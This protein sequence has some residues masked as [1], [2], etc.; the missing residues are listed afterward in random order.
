M[1]GRENLSP[2]WQPGE[3]GNPA[4]CS[5]KVRERVLLRDFIHDCLSSEIPEDL[6]EKLQ[7]LG[8][9]IAAGQAIALNV[10]RS[11]LLGNAKAID[12]ILGTEP[13]LLELSGGIEVEPLSHRYVPTADDQ[14]ALKHEIT[15]NGHD[16]SGALQ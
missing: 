3:T 8:E 14:Q 4:G 10:I 6:R 1:K 16:T 9:G 5:R 13:K 7:E 2:P 12:Q 15:G 11:A